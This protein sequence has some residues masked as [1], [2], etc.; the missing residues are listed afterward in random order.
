M[1]FPW[2]NWVILCKTVTRTS[3]NIGRPQRPSCR[4]DKIRNGMDRT[5]R[6]WFI[7]SSTNH[8]GRPD[9]LSECSPAEISRRCLRLV[10]CIFCIVPTCLHE[11]YNP[12]IEVVQYQRG[13]GNLETSVNK[14]KLQIPG[15]K[16]V[17]N[18]CNKLQLLSGIP[19]HSCDVTVSL[20]PVQ[21]DPRNLKTYTLTG[22]FDCI[23]APH[24][25]HVL[26]PLRD[27]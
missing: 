25:S 4:T 21:T 10:A 20:N 5:L 13:M 6:Y 9:P 15:K 27:I 2:W 1:L 11:D 19:E 17:S 12:G 22:N 7:G 23:F 18:V 8:R 14:P 24:P 16:E 3:M 26:G